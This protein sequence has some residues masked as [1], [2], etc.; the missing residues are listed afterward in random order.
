MV[1]VIKKA[2]IVTKKAVCEHCG[3]TLEYVQ[4]D[5]HE[6]QGTDISGGSDGCKYIVCPNC[7]KKVILESW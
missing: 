3:V 1:K 2:P 6:I 4:N 7:A 5:V